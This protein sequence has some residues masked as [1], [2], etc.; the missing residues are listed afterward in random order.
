M[1]ICDVELRVEGLI[2]LPLGP[3]DAVERIL[4][5]KVKIRLPGTICRWAAAVTRE[6]SRIPEVVCDQTKQLR[7]V[8]V[9]EIVGGVRRKRRRKV[10]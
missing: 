7:D 4:S 8:T 10:V 6:V 1:R 3:E 5:R 2:T 9:I